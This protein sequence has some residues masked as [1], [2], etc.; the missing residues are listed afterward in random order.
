MYL[1]FIK[2]VQFIIYVYSTIFLGHPVQVYNARVHNV[3]VYEYIYYWY[4][5]LSLSGVLT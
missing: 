2:Y 1:L 4:Y 3:Q 5:L